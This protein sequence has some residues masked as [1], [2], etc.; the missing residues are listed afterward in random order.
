[1]E[2]FGRLAAP[3]ANGLFDLMERSGGLVIPP[4]KPAESRRRERLFKIGNLELVGGYFYENLAIASDVEV[5]AD[6]DH[7]PLAELARRRHRLAL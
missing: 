5:V 3:G 2:D 4:N 7:L 1:V 6:I